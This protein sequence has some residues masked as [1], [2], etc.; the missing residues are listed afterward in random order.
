MLKDVPV[1][2]KSL[3]K[4]TNPGSL[5]WQVFEKLYFDHKKWKII[6]IQKSQK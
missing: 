4:K 5:S 6:S 1:K 3:E 2:R